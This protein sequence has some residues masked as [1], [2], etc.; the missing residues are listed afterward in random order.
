MSTIR[1]R[2]TRL[3]ER[4]GYAIT[5]AVDEALDDFVS[6]LADRRALE[7]AD[8]ELD[9]EDAGD[10][11]A[12]ERTR[13]IACPHCGERIAIAIDLSGEDQDDIQDCEVC[14]SPIR[15]TYTVEDGKLTS[16]SAESS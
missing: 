6:A 3:L 1:D 4:R 2:L 8:D 14:C 11:E 10:S 13:T 12:E 15:I 7:A 16:F 9:D 5:D